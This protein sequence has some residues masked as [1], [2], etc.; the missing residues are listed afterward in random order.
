MPI[1]AIAEDLLTVREASRCIPGAP[2]DRRYSPLV[3]EDRGIWLHHQANKA[4]GISDGTQRTP[5]R[6]ILDVAAPG[7]L[8]VHP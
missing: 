3:E 8:G 5:L 6:V 1:D 2:H 4:I 7:R